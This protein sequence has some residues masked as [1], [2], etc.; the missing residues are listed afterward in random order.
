MDE[1]LKKRVPSRF[2]SLDAMRGLAALVVVIYHYH[3]FFFA[4]WGATEISR[5]GDETFIA[6]Y[7]PN[8]IPFFR[9]FWVFYDDGLLGVDLFFGLSG[10]IFYWLFSSKIRNKTL[11][12][13]SFSIQRFS[14]LYPLHFLTLTWVTGLLLIFKRTH[15]GVD[16][17]SFDDLVNY[18]LNFMLI[19]S[20]GIGDWRSFNAPIWSVSVEV[21]LY[22]MFFLLSRYFSLKNMGLILIA[23]FGLFVI[24][25]INHQIGHGV[26][27]F[28]LGGVTYHLYEWIVTRNQTKSVILHLLIVLCG[29]MWVLGIVGVYRQW[30]PLETIPFFWRYTFIPAI[31]IFQTT[32]LTLALVE[33]RW[34]TIGNSLAVLGDISYSVYLIHFPLQVTLVTLVIY[35]GK[36]QE[37]FYNPYIYL[38]FFA[39]LLVLSAISHYYFERPVQRYLRERWLSSP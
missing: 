3:K 1:I 24:Y 29:L 17:Y 32:I 14:R 11:G 7:M 38:S 22:I 16:F 4:A 31:L 6:H 28:F 34:K 37:I 33:T 5:L 18:L 39:L 27:S 21:M 25:R 2:Y 8:K 9:L 19:S 12:F 26:F 20:W 35:F 36:S 15:I 10:F 13:K 30:N 23:F